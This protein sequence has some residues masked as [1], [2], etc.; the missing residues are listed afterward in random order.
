MAQ[1]IPSI[2]GALVAMTAVFA[3]PIQ[4]W[5]AGHPVIAGVL[6]GVGV[7]ISHL[8]PSPVATTVKP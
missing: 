6:A 7:I 1:W 4:V 8:V 5:I 3:D 2:I